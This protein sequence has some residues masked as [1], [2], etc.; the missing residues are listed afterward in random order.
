M[1]QKQLRKFVVFMT[2]LWLLTSESQII[3]VINH[4]EMN[5]DR[6][7]HQ[8]AS[9]ELVECNPCKSIQESTLDFIPI[10]KMPP[11]E[12]DRKREN[13]LRKC[14]TL[15]NCGNVVLFPNKN[16]RTRPHSTRI[17]RKKYWM[18]AGLFYFIYHTAQSAGAVEYTN[19]ISAEE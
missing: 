18:S 5:P 10:H 7:T 8:N 14:L 12:K 1:L 13:L 19:Y 9:R 11:L 15:I 3:L 16:Y 17:T 6:N 4:W 2:K